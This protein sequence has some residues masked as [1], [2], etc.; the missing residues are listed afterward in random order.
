M[1]VVAVRWPPVSQVRAADSPEMSGAARCCTTR[2]RNAH[3][4]EEREVLYPWHPWAGCH[5]HVHEIVQKGSGAVA[6][7][8]RADDHSGR[9][10]ELSVWMFDRAA[11]TTMRIAPAPQV[12][13]TTILTLTALLV[14]VRG[15]RSAGS[16]SSSTPRAVR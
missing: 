1:W 6:R 13:S 2:L 14:D 4:T 5:V 12:D 3:R 8:H 7:C 15:D 11:C 16:S 10:L 9:C